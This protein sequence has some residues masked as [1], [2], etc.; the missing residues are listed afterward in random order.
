MTSLYELAGTREV[1]TFEQ[2]FGEKCPFCGR[3]WGDPTKCDPNP[4]DYTIRQALAAIFVREKVERDCAICGATFEVDARSTRKY[5]GDDCRSAA[6]RQIN[7]IAQ[8]KHRERLITTRTCEFCT[9]EFSTHKRE[10]RF[11]SLRCANRA[12]GA[13]RRKAA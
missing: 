2:R 9:E 3:N 4:A 10:Q 1:R 8:A 12:L 6:V 7:R 11:C 13:R 5:C